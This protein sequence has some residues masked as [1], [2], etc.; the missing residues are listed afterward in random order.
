MRKIERKLT[1]SFDQTNRGIPFPEG[2]EGIIFILKVSIRLFFTHDQNQ[3]QVS[4]TTQ[5]KIEKREY[6]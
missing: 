4:N 6:P 5:M 3:A 2:L 1:T